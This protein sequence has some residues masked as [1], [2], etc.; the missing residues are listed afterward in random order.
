MHEPT[1]AKG[2][3]NVWRES[4][5]HREHNVSLKAFARRVRRGGLAELAKGWLRRKMAR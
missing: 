2:L 4:L 5:D 1:T 3:K